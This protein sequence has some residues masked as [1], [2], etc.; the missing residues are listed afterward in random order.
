[1]GSCGLGG[2]IN[3]SPIFGKG[4]EALNMSGKITD[5]ASFFL[6]AILPG[7]STLRYK[8]FTVFK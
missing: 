6:F 4:G 3:P 5:A 7:F 8:Q 1:M 2:R